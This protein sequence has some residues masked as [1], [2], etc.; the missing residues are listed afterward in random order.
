MPN[1]SE[2]DF[3]THLRYLESETTA[4]SYRF[5]RDS[6][7]RSRYLR[8]AREMA[9]EFRHAVKLGKLSPEEA[10]K[11]CH[12]LRQ[13]YVG[14]FRHEATD[15]G[16]A[17][18]AFLKKEGPSLNQLQNLYSFKLFKKKFS[19]LPMSHKERVWR[20]IIKAAGRPNQRVTA[21]LKNL[22]RV[23]KITFVLSVGIYA[24]EVWDSQEPKK[25]AIKGGLSLLGG[26]LAGMGLT[27]LVC[28]PAA[29]IC[30][31]VTILVGAFAGSLATET[32]S[33]FFW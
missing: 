8:Y 12:A 18:A 22:G 25:T 28:G 17:M 23:G 4:F 10:A 1:Q 21:V 15:L 29:P 5:I 32:L 14:Q 19:H 31:G 7:V 33:D 11:R 24:Y 30:V 26:S 16:R 13:F 6:Y 9:W 2:K 27:T 20:E 3:E